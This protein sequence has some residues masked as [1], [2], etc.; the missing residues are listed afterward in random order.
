VAAHEA[1]DL[2]KLPSVERV[3]AALDDKHPNEVI[4]AAARLA[5]D[6]ARLKV[7]AGEGAPSFDHVVADARGIVEDHGR[8][9]LGPVINATGVLLHTNLGRAPL[10]PRQLTAVARVA[11][12]Y[13]NLEYDLTTGARG[14][15][16][17]HAKGLLRALT[18][19]E[20]ALVVNNNAAAVMVTL[21]GLCGGREVIISRGE[22]VEI[23]GEFR[24][25]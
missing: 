1:G 19:A 10:G 6:A 15:R 5:I 17:S 2:S 25:P 4:V 14:S 23:G 24:I 7:R 13:S 12:G 3:R 21:A 11:G 16:Y 18:G 20:D 22:L 9:L 8:S